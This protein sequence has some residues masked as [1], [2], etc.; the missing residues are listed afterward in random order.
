MPDT[1]KTGEDITATL[2]REN[3]DSSDVEWS[4]TKDGQAVDIA[5]VTV[6][7]PDS[8]GAKFNFTDPGKYE[9]T[10]KTTDPTG[11]EVKETH[12]IIISVE[13]PVQDN[14]I[15]IIESTEQLAEGTDGENNQTSESA[16]ETE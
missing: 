14:S 7:T 4:I 16:A 15:D 2:T 1:A 12:T 6:E 3:F 5:D 10:V 13:E 11:D 8:A 9:I